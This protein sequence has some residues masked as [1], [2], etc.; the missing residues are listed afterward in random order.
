MLNNM[1]V[2]TELNIVIGLLSVLLIGVGALGV[3]GVN[4]SNMGLKTVFEDRTRYP[5]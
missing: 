3:Y 5:Q 4:Q 1:T 2:K